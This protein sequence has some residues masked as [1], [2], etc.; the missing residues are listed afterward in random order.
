MQNNTDVTSL[1]M[2]LKKVG[3]G[4]LWE[5]YRSEGECFDREREGGRKERIGPGKRS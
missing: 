3:R 2:Q 1:S 4:L 5:A